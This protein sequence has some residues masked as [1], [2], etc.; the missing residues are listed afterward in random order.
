[1]GTFNSGY[2]IQASFIERVG[3]PS[4]ISYNRELIFS[5]KQRNNELLILAWERFKGL[6][7]E[8]EH[9]LRD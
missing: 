2:N 5:F 3:P 6:A 8:L 7:Y 9:G 4:I 1:L